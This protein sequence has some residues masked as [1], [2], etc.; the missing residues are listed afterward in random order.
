MFL[1]SSTGANLSSLEIWDLRK[2]NPAMGQFLDESL[3][4]LAIAL[5]SRKEEL[6]D[7]NGELSDLSDTLDHYMDTWYSE[8]SSIPFGNRGSG[9][10]RR[11]AYIVPCPELHPIPYHILKG[12]IE[13]SAGKVGLEGLLCLPQPQFFF[14]L[15]S[16]AY[17]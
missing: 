11:T 15:P 14:S 5:E 1:Q 13:H 12:L 3:A 9:H 2:P 6:R 7:C 10:A 17:I 16:A 4:S 8:I